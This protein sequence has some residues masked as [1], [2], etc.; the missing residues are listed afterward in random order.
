M[1]SAVLVLLVVS[2]GLVPACTKGG[3]SDDGVLLKLS[4]ADKRRVF[5]I[6][7]TIPIKLAFSS[8]EKERYQLDEAHGDR[9]GRMNFEQFIVTPADGAVDPVPELVD[10][11]GGLTNYSFLT[12]KPWTIELKLNEW[13][14]FTKPGDYRLVVTSKRVEVP[15]RSSPSGTSPVITR[16]N[17]IT[18]RICAADPGWQRRVWQ[19]AAA[20]LD[21]LAPRKSEREDEW[22]TA[23]ANAIDALRFLGTADAAREMAKRL[24][25]EDH[26]G[27]F[28]CYVGLVST[29]ERA[30]AREGLEQ[31]LIDPQHPITDRFLDAYEVVALGAPAFGSPVGAEHH[32]K[33]WEKLIAALPAKRGNA[34]AISLSTATRDAWD[35]GTAPAETVAALAEQLVAIFDELPIEQ[36]TSVLESHWEK[37]ASAELLPL[38]QRYAMGANTRR[39]AETALKRWYEL[40]PA[41]VRRTMIAEIMSPRPRFD[42]RVLARLPDE[43]L[44]EADHALAYNFVSAT[45]SDANAVAALIARYA[46]KAILPQV[47]AKFDAYIG[48]AACDIQESVLAYMLRVD[49]N[50]ARP[51]IE[52]ALAA[53]GATGCFR[54]VFTSV[55]EI[56]YHPLL[57]EI[58]VR[59]LD[60]PDLE[61]AADAAKTLGR[62]GTASA[63]EPLWRRFGRWS[64][65]WEGRELEIETA[66]VAR[67]TELE[68][69][70]WLGRALSDAV[71]LGRG[72]IAD[73]HA[74]QRLCS[75][76]GVYNVQQR[77]EQHLALW[78]NDAALITAHATRGAVYGRVAQYEYEGF[79]ALE[80]K[81]SQFPPVT[82]FRLSVPLGA[83]AER[84]EAVDLVR[85]LLRERGFAFDE[86][87]YDY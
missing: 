36:Q 50:S 68:H 85:T 4:L 27:D 9:S 17:A 80:A 5:R 16:S 75:L 66:F 33:G 78:K 29:P 30:A 70:L 1:R 86:E 65:Q 34:R 58:A 73:R 35:N 45:D 31:A 53:R 47:A 79:D 12:R 52:K 51:R 28:Y 13:V 71:A 18:V 81:L 26:N 64:K 84:N 83:A 22:Q 23:R 42:A 15:D 48:Q 74:L 46:T 19:K 76:S 10:S 39:L 72:W 25:G 60:D 62:F 49:P 20:T 55:S 41:G 67:R 40:D 37:L 56:H 44:P 63:E 57:Q 59:S 24:R 87:P 69:E 2:S 54:S 7:E 43:T 14:R 6:G 8:R 3:G 32:R 77:C 82:K 21:Q 61:V 38:V 11:M